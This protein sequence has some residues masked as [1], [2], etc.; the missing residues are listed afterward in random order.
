MVMATFVVSIFVGCVLD[1]IATDWSGISTLI[2][3]QNVLQDTANVY[4]CMEYKPMS[5]G[6]RGKKGSN[7]WKI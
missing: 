1:M 7:K 4:R 6:L 5:R 3:F 2:F